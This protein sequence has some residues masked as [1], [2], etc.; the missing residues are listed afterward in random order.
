MLTPPACVFVGAQGPCLAWPGLSQ[1]LPGDRTW[2][3]PVPAPRPGMLRALLDFSPW[4]SP[5][6][7]AAQEFPSV[8]L[9]TPSP[10]ACP[11]ARG[12]DATEAAAAGAQLCL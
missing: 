10:R 12:A 8:V 9:S 3:W 1:E 7:P 6:G 11:A 4:I 5:P 2:G